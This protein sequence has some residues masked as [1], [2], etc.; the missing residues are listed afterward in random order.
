MLARQLQQAARDELLRDC[1]Y[2]D[3]AVLIAD[4]D[5]AFFALATLLGE[6]EWFDGG[7][8]GNGNAP[9]LFDASVFAY[10]YLCLDEEGRMGMSYNPLAHAIRKYKGLERHA[11]RISEMY[12]S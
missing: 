8:E 10:T 7:E 9:G 5:A 12:F 1:A 11:K 2:V 4:A 6:R 3:E